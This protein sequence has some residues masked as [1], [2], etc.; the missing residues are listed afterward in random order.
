[1]LSVDF[2]VGTSKLKLLGGAVFLYTEQIGL[3]V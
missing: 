1:M 2:L 3:I